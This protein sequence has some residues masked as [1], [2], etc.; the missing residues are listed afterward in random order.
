MVP[1][2][3]F[4][5]AFKTHSGQYQFRVMPFGLT[6]APATFQCLMNT[7]FAPYLRKFVLVF[8][9]DI[10][11]YSKT[12]QQHIE[13]LKVVL[14]ILRDHK[15]F[16]KR[17]KCTFAQ[18]QL[19]YLGHIISDKGVST[20][21][22]KIE[23]MLKWPV[24]TNITEL[25]GFLGLTGYYRK[26]VQ[27]YGIIAKPLTALLKKKAFQWTAEAQVAFE[28]LKE[29]MAST[30]VL[31][32]PN[33]QQPFA[34][35]TDACDTC[36]GA[37]LTQNGHTVA[38]YSKALGVN[39]QKLSIYEKE[40]LAVMMA[41]EKWR[42]YLLRGPFVIKTDH[43]SLCQLGD[44]ILTTD[45]QKKAMTKLVGLQ[46]QFQYKKGCDNKA[47]DALSRVG[48]LLAVNSLSH[49]QP[50]WLQEVI[51][52]YAVHTHAQALL[53]LAISAIHPDNYVLKDGVITQAGRIWIG[54]NAALKT[55]LISAFHASA[56]G[57]HSGIQATFQ[58]VKKLFVWQG[59]KQDVAEFVQQY[60]VCQQAK[61]AHCKF[62]GLLN[63]LPVP[64]GPGTDITMDFISLAQV[65]WIHCHFGCGGS[66]QKICSFYPFKVSLH[67]SSGSSSCSEQCGEIT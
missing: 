9:D 33:F 50:V 17:S 54:A 10:L 4:K 5:T 38:F 58:R 62:P 43:Q 16:A 19:E 46:F 61:H 1:Q 29:S 27:H 49:S 45:L 22:D 55:K 3:E 28:K 8:M 32:L 20:D 11:V 21:S 6:N 63:P 24:P 18:T 40:F 2:D 51:N 47:V 7:I 56:I 57:G 42:L 25:R 66:L 35:E 67:S 44:Q 37:V 39:N 60:K 26:F 53:Q 14:E 52:S 34:I 65:T 31:V 41:V 48:H 36:I 15:L 64:A 59:M 30:S 13:H 12:L 23:A